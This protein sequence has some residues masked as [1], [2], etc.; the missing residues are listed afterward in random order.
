MIR[1]EGTDQLEAIGARLKEASDHALTNSVRAS[2]RAVAKPLGESVLHEGA[3]KM[4]HRGGLAARVASLGKVGVSSA[5][6]QKNVRVVLL[7]RNTGVAMKALDEG[8]VRHPVYGN[9]GNW[10]AQAV[11]PHAFTEAFK[12]QQAQVQAAL[13]AAG[14]STLNGIAG[15]LK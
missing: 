8:V 12:H 10:V 3:E 4:P 13:L 11:R 5:L 9:R 2:M 15:D 6:V 14:E 7:L 1:T